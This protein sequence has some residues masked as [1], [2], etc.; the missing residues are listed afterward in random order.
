M[1]IVFAL[2]HLDLRRGIRALLICLA[3]VATI[4]VVALVGTA[5][6]HS[7]FSS[8]QAGV[9]VAARGAFRS[10]PSAPAQGVSSTERARLSSAYGRLPL[11]F[12]PNR[13]QFDARALYVARGQ[14][15]TLFLTHWAAVL[16][17]ASARGHHRAELTIGFL[18]A[19]RRAGVSAAARRGGQVNYL[20][21]RDRSRW[22]R[23]V[24]VYGRVS[25]R[26]LW[27]GVSAVF[28]GNQG[29]LEYDFDVSA[30]ADPGRIAL[31]FGG[32][33][34]LRVERSGALSVSLRG[35]VVRQLGPHAYQL[36]GGRRHVVA[37]R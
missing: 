35:G 17:L 30:G 25:Y 34:A 14:G 12:E 36:I 28:Y 7:A 3:G 16:S 6:R 22:H 31:S 26:N 10:L 13:G 4:L 20:I 15:Y 5:S 8:G 24:P 23:N 1:T 33:R 11:A 37:S 32:A 2:A 27:P 19:S 21:G 9:R 29:R 18:G